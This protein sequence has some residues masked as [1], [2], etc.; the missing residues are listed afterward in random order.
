MSRAK[1]RSDG[2]GGP[3]AI[4]WPETCALSRAP[5]PRDV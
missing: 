5:L 3:A 1:L 2:H 4:G